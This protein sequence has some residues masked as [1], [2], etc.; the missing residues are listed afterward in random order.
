MSELTVYE[1]INFQGEHFNFGP[2]TYMTA[3]LRD[4]HYFNFNDAISSL[5]VGPNTVVELFNHGSMS[6]GDAPDSSRVII[7]PSQVADLSTIG[8]NDKI[9]TI[10]VRKFVRENSYASAHGAVTVSNG[11]SFNGKN[12]TLPQGQ[13][14]AARLSS[15]EFKFDDN[16][17]RSIFVD[18]FT[19]AILYDDPNL[20]GTKN[21][22]AILGPRRLND[23]NAIG[24]DNKL[25]S[26]EVISLEKPAGVRGD[27]H[28]SDLPAPNDPLRDALESRAAG[29]GRLPHGYE[30][31]PANY[32]SVAAGALSGPS[33]PPKARPGAYHGDSAGSANIQG[34]GP[35]MMLLVLMFILI[36]VAAVSAGIAYG[37][38]Q[39]PPLVPVRR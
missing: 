27:V 21:A 19:L 32:R 36:V 22:I 34:V 1:D 20:D 8:F 23:L 18:E 4:T 31:G 17:I 25:S 9:S 10:R 39:K 28:P 33:P 15:S 37:A 12:R 14:D 38:L 24:F 13:Y 2:G 7:G 30:A 26:L 35:S 5:R 16:T 29:P 6:S 3:D 11:Y